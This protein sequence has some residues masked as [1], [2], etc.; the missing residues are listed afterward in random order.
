MCLLA[1]GGPLV[2]VVSSLKA[3]VQPGSVFGGPGARKRPPEAENEEKAKITKIDD[4][5]T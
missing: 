1:G 3:V 4:E 5:A 2:V